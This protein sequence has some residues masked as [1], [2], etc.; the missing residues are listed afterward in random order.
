MVDAFIYEMMMQITR[1]SQIRLMT[2]TRNAET[3]DERVAG[4]ERVAS[5]IQKSFCVT[6]SISI[7]LGPHCCG[8][9][10]DYRW[11]CQR[12]GGAA[13]NQET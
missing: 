1:Q 7:I 6:S 11:P 9:Q 8:G 2:K 3:R 12:Q 10:H 13:L 4:G 5:G